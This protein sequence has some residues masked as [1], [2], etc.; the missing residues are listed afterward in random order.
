MLV[1]KRRDK[2]LQKVR[3]IW[4]ENFPLYWGVQVVCVEP[5]RFANFVDLL[6][7]GHA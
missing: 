6:D 3:S 5:R 1:L 4:D 2:Y 7:L